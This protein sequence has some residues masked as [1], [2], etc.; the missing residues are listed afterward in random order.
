MS[1]TASQFAAALPVKA[2]D[3]YFRIQVLAEARARR[4]GHADPIQAGK[5]AV[6]LRRSVV[7]KDHEP[8]AEM[9][10]TTVAGSFRR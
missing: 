10:L 2:D 5:D 1:T 7:A 8:S 4:N 9:I 3:P 6:E